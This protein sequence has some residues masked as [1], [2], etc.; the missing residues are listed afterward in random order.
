MKNGVKTL[1]SNFIV[2]KDGKTA[3]RWV[4]GT[5]LETVVMELLK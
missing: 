2:G 3:I 1:L 4:W 5:A